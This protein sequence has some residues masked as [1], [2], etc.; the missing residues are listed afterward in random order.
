M[1]AKKYLALIVT[2]F[3]ASMMVSPALAQQRDSDGDGLPDGNDNCP[4]E[5]GPRSNGG[6]PFVVV[7]PPTNPDTDDDGLPDSDDAC[8]TVAGPRENQGCPQTAPPNNPPPT[9]PDP[10]NPDPDN[11]RPVD[12][13][14]DGVPDNDDRCPDEAGIVDNGG[15]P[16]PE[17]PFN[18]PLLPN[19]A[20]YVTASGDFMARVR[21]FPGM[22]E[23]HIG[24][25]TAG[26]IY[27]AQGIVNTSEGQW[28]RL[29]GEFQHLNYEM[30]GGNDGYVSDA[31]VNHSGC[32]TIDEPISTV[33]DFQVPQFNLCHLTVG[34]DST[35]WS[36]N[37]QVPN[38]T[39][40]SFWFAVS[41][42]ATIPVGASPLVNWDDRLPAFN[43]PNG[44]LDKAFH[45]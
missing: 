43:Y 5:S 26:V 9:N 36:N 3:I 24:N 38:Y 2:I 14:G 42:G 11:S 1:F 13:D 16:M 45:I 18:P 15:C 34:F 10:T 29:S 44:F 33:D 21:L 20:C 25:L 17:T 30:W 28:I 19:D 4:T 27:P 40:A 22:V 39:Y 31:V 8:P 32:P 6:C 35:T 12:R 41:P 23:E 37:P 7:I